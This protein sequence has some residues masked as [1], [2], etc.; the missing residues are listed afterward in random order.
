MDTLRTT[1]AVL[2]IVLPLVGLAPQGT[3][4]QGSQNH[5]VSPVGRWTEGPSLTAT[6]RDDL[7]YVGNG[8]SLEIVEVS[9]PANPAGQGRVSFPGPV[10]DV[11]VAGNYAYVVSGTPLYDDADLHV[12]DITDPTNPQ[13][14]GT[15]ADGNIFEMAAAGDHA[16]LA[17]GADGL[18]VLDISDPTDPQQVG[19]LENSEFGSSS[20]GVAV[21][22][23][24]AYVAN[25]Q[26]GLRVV[27]VSAPA[28]PQQV[29]NSVLARRAKDVAVQGDSAYVA[30]TSEE[31]DDE[32]LYVID[33]SDPTDSQYA[34]DINTDDTARE[35]AVQGDHAY[36]ATSWGVRVIDASGSTAPKDVG[37]FEADGSAYG[38]VARDGHVYLAAD[39][40]LRVLDITNPADPQQTGIFE[41]GGNIFSA[42]ARDDHAYVAAGFGGLQVL[43]V[44]NPAD[45]QQVGS[46]ETNGE[47]EDVAVAG[48]HAYVASSN[49]LQV[50]DVS[51]P[52]NP[53]QTDS[54]ETDDKGV[55]AGIALASDHA[56]I[57]N[58]TAFIGF[59]IEL[60]VFDVSGFTGSQQ[61]DEVTTGSAAVAVQDGYLYVADADLK[62]LDVS[63]PANPQEVGSFETQGRAK[64]VAA[65]GDYAYV[66]DGYSG[67]GLQVLDVSDPANPQAVGSYG[68]DDGSPFNVT[69]AGDYA[70]LVNQNVGPE[71]PD[72]HVLDVSDPT[73]P[74]QDG[75]F[76]VGGSPEGVTVAN[77]VIYFATE[78]AGLYVLERST[79]SSKTVD[80]DGPVDF[81]ET[82]VDIT[83]SDVSGSGDV[84]V[85]RFG[86]PPVS[87]DGISEENVSDYRVVIEAGGDLSFGSGTEVRFDVSTLDGVDTPSDVTIYKRS[88]PGEGS[89]TAL[90]TT[91]DADAGELVATMS[92]FSEFVFASDTNSLPTESR[93]D[94]PQKFALQGN[95]P[96]PFRRSTTIRYA[97]PQAAN[98]TLTVYDVLGRRVRT[99]VSGEKQTPGRKQIR[100]TADG[101][102]AGVYVV[103][104]QAGSFTETRR[105]VVVE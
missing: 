105:M 24:Y 83:F 67:A 9:D 92:S 25:D 65:A 20:Q 18:R 79:T 103:R 36:L 55:A 33:I 102:S 85:E 54:L 19:H 90:S 47:A 80:A 21:A 63:D 96:N 2:I 39:S 76:E 51:D 82:G 29:D 15:F 49:G 4:A 53:Q 70:Y 17:A 32:D 34:G 97:L 12:V 31:A 22:G 5:N 6:V 73:Y 101:L 8:P 40:G 3:A 100:F 43:D 30:T 78:T 75:F 44:S 69:V 16:Y 99:L 41:V 86:T 68:P 62:V 56:Y 23:N 42:A 13:K 81:G 26:A 11:T 64:G 35:V 50:V 84:T 7:A 94:A 46:V 14:V 77:G 104:M 66:A 95:A 27:D 88:T 37:F 91:Y 48:D 57:A 52:T 1:T 87:P 38:I 71:D 93:A 28:N 10:G 60:G 74:K 61:D 89:F 59:N 98:V 58:Q 45:P 72:L